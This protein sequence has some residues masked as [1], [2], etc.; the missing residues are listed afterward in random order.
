MI[1]KKQAKRQFIPKILLVFG[2]I[3]IHSKAAEAQLSGNY[4]IDPAFSAPGNYQSFGDAVND[5]INSGISGQVIFNIASGTYNEQVEI[6]GIAGTS[7]SSRIIFRGATG[8]PAN[9]KLEYL[10]GFPSNY[11]VHL[12]GANHISFEDIG[13]HSLSTTA[14][15]ARAIW[16]SQGMSFSGVS[17]IQFK[18]CNFTTTYSQFPD[19]AAIY[20][21][22]ATE[23]LQ[24]KDCDFGHTYGIYLNASPFMNHLNLVIEGNTFDSRGHA[25]PSAPLLPNTVFQP[26]YLNWA[27][28]VQ[29]RK[30]SI[31]RSY[32]SSFPNPAVVVE[33]TIGLDFYLNKISVENGGCARFNSINSSFSTGSATIYNNILLDQYSNQAAILDI[34]YS[35]NVSVYHNT[36]YSGYTQVSSSGMLF[37]VRLSGDIFGSGNTGNSFFNNLIYMQSGTALTLDDFCGF[38]DMDYNLYFCNQQNPLFDKNGTKFPDL[39]GFVN[40]VYPGNDI[41]SFSANPNFNNFF[42]FYPQL[43]C[44]IGRVTNATDDYYG[45]SRNGQFFIGAVRGPQLEERNITPIAVLQPSYPIISGQQDL[46]F[47]VKNLGSKTITNLNANYILNGNAAISNSYTTSIA[48]CATDT[49]AFTGSKQINLQNLINTLKV[50]TDSP[51]SL[52]DNQPENDTIHLKLCVALKGDYVLGGSNSDFA[53]LEALYANLTC[54]GIDSVVNIFIK[55]G[56]YIGGIYLDEVKG[57]SATNRLNF[58]GDGS[59]VRIQLNNPFHNQQSAL[60]V[61]GTPYVSFRHIEFQSTMLYS[62]RPI[63]QVFRESH[64]VVI[65]SCDFNWGGPNY[66][67][68]SNGILIGEDNFMNSSSGASNDIR[69]TNSRIESSSSAIKANGS[70]NNTISRLVIH[71][72]DFDGSGVYGLN[73]SNLDELEFTNN[74]I[75]AGTGWFA[76]QSRYAVF[77]EY[78]S[79]SNIQSNYIHG[80][81]KS[82]IWSLAENSS[83]FSPGSSS[84]VNNS[85]ALR[86]TDLSSEIYGLR[87]EAGNYLKVVHNTI[88]VEEAQASLPGQF[89]H[90]GVGLFFQN[91]TYLINNIIEHIG[92]DSRGGAVFLS[93]SSGVFWDYNLYFTDVGEI[94][95]QENNGNLIH[96]DLNFWMNSDFTSNIN[97]MVGRAQFKSSQDLHLK[98]GV[99]LMSGSDTLAIQSDIDGDAR[100]AFA[101]TVGADETSYPHSPLTASMLS[102][103]SL[104]LGS[105]IKFTNTTNTLGRPHLIHWYLD[106]SP[107]G[108]KPS[109]LF[110]IQDTL[111][112]TL[113]MT[114]QNC[115]YG[116]SVSQILKMKVPTSVPVSDFIAETQVIEL[117]GSI[118][119]YDKSLHG[120]NQFSWKT[121]PSKDVF[122][123]NAFDPKPIISFLKPG[124]YDVCLE[125]SNTNGQGNDTCKKN[126]I[127]VRENYAMCSSIAG[128]T[129][130]SE[131]Y[132]TDD[133]SNAFGGYSNNQDC[134]LVIDPCA[135]EITF[136]V[137]QLN[138]ADAG[139]RLQVFDGTD[140]TGNLLY[141][142]AGPIN[143]FNGIPNQF[144]ATTGKLYIKWRTNGNATAAGW[145]INYNSTPSNA[146]SPIAN[147]IVPDTVFVNR[148]YAFTCS[149]LEPNAAYVWDFD[150]PNQESGLEANMFNSRKYSWNNAGNYAIRHAI[151]TCSG[152]DEVIKNISVVSPTSSPLAGFQAEDQRLLVQKSTR[153]I[154]TSLYGA[155]RFRWKITPETGV[156]FLSSDTVSEV[157][158]RFMKTG[159]YT[160]KLIVEN[161][162]GK[163]SII[164]QNHIEVFDYCIP[165]N[166]SLNTDLGISSFR[167]DNTEHSSAI[168]LSAYSDY[169]QSVGPINVTKGGEYEMSLKRNSAINKMNRKVW[170]DYNLDGHFDSSE[171][172]AFEA[173]AQT[174]NYLT[175]IKIPRSVQSGLVR[176]RAST[177]L[178]SETNTPCGMNQSGEYEDYL[179]NIQN[180]I[181]SPQVQLLG[182]DTLYVEQWHAFLDPGILASDEIDGVI[183]QIQTISN[184]DSTTVGLYSIQYIVT[185]T[186]GNVNAKAKRYIQ[187]T[188]DMTKPLLVLAG[189]LTDTLEVLNTYLE[190]GYTATDYFNRNLTGQV[191]VLNPIDSSIIG[192]YEIKYRIEDLSGNADSATRIVYV[193]DNS[194]PVIQLIGADTLTLAVFDTYQEPGV[195]ATDNYSSSISINT[196]IGNLNTS[197]TGTYWITYTA[198]DA[199]GNISTRSRVIRVLDTLKPTLHL[200]G[201]DTVYL[202]VYSGYQ[203][204][205]VLVNDNYCKDLSYTSIGFPNSNLLDIYT[206]KYYASDCEGNT[207]DTISRVVKVLDR[208]SPKLILKGLTLEKVQRYTPYSDPYVQVSDNYYSA[209]E[210]DTLIEKVTNY[211]D[212]APEGLYEICYDVTDPSGN[213]ADKVCRTIQVIE[214]TTG[215]DENAE[216]K[217]SIY[218]NPTSGK[219]Y[220]E[221]SDVK[222]EKLQVVLY[223]LD[224]KKIKSIEIESQPVYQLNLIDV[225]P[226]TYILQVSGSQ[227]V[228]RFKVVKY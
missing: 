162:L 176:L 31:N 20:C 2:L 85:I 61:K 113:K 182:P 153:L 41:H 77:L 21:A 169:S 141:T 180:D 217:I 124:R 208:V 34:G 177:E 188:E 4:T 203:E 218:P 147:F 112:H 151:E 94:Y 98:L 199:S 205:G 184:F 128:I 120:A 158:V 137:Q 157:R 228:S 186:A 79:N 212:G 123:D 145:K 179:L 19:N 56:T 195:I 91:S 165:A 3:F 226:G 210:L 111:S 108:T 16:I 83:P 81:F 156:N 222:Q 159:W 39:V 185:D 121:W 53:D 62:T 136:E 187:V 5:L 103:D 118:Q 135:T 50:F 181:T 221:L 130:V 42:D 107:L 174:M 167:F 106:G 12:S 76:G 207:S 163:D 17:D 54:A 189:S 70:F 87:L 172:V 209:A 140:S 171:L 47:T 35:N 127:L 131:G 100:C 109:I 142:V 14:N 117:N 27:S 139:D 215:L 214:N 143:A 196:N 104:F 38:S 7:T 66:S 18:N 13:I 170:I 154:D 146:S 28:G 43:A 46:L 155:Y 134:Q 194:D 216:Q 97:S 132:I 23:G 224:G 32:V 168:G 92:Q 29:I 74:R 64:Q 193:L 33:G 191:D 71:N 183:T 73:S 51:N 192:K 161:D 68:G 166:F 206:V 102:N 6:P 115:G 138:L 200:V 36:I 149:A 101:P 223:A 126:Y 227:G 48:T 80:A 90:A 25:D 129:K 197:E 201:L 89:P 9:T 164:Q 211:Y 37:G 11:V 55:P 219:V 190:P 24:I 26:I 125:T 110:T 178:D 10:T 30:N 59:G 95:N 133:Q 1:L 52:P 144:K 122:F 60:V 225:L 88:S 173:S 204:S 160:V 82:G 213:I 198:E 8:N 152:N 72:C 119:F 116:D 63:A 15:E 220:I 49:F 114:I 99:D 84:I 86:G 78:C 93:N 40:Q 148:L 58:I 44:L 22:D 175:T 45:Q 202:D 67:Y 75:E 65:D 105:L 69:I 150:Y 57:T 96:G